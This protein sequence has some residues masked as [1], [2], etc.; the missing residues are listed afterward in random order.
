MVLHATFVPSLLLGFQTVRWS[1]WFTVCQSTSQRL[2]NGTIVPGPDIIHAP[3]MHLPCGF[4]L[5]ESHILV[6]GGRSTTVGHLKSAAIL[7]VVTRTVDPCTK[8]DTYKVMV[9]FILILFEIS[10]NLLLVGTHFCCILAILS[11]LQKKSF[12]SCNFSA[13][14]I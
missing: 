11:F 6:A 10:I 13:G 4:K 8:H 2:P 7:N 5:N 9:A 1:Y 12:F 14:Q 3:T